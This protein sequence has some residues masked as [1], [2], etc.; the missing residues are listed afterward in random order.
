M[1]S[2]PELQ[3]GLGKSSL[4]FSAV[5]ALGAGCVQA[6]A[7]PRAALGALFAALLP[8]AEDAAAVRTS[9]LTD[10]WSECPAAGSMDKHGSRMGRGRPRAVLAPGR[11]ASCAQLFGRY[12]AFRGTRAPGQAGWNTGDFRR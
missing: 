10:G 8:A 7:E 12:G 4:L 5:A 9:R 3:P 11:A 1:F 6:W 2:D